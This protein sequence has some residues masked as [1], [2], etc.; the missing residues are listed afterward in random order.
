MT[1]EEKK[2]EMTVVPGQ[3]LFVIDRGALVEIAPVVFAPSGR[4]PVLVEVTVKMVIDVPRELIADID[5]SESIKPLLDGYLSA[6]SIAATDIAHQV[7]FY[8]NDSSHCASN[9]LR[10]LATRL[11]ERSSG[12]ACN[13]IESKFV[14]A[15]TKEDQ[16]RYHYE[17]EE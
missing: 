11:E 12:C 14:R 1:D 5:E 4:I 15:A 13:H 3:R 9:E 10:K 6:E 16:E 17:P 8:L 2:P 7:E